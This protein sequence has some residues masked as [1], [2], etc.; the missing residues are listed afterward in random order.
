M[1]LVQYREHTPAVSGNNEWIELVAP[2]ASLANQ[3]ATTEFV[4][5]E[6]RNKPDAITACILYGAELGLG[7]MVSLSK[8]AVIQG[9]PA[10]YAELGRALALAAGH[11]IWV[12]ES[13][14]TR[15]TVSG[16]RKGS[17]HVQTVTW[18]SDDV[19]K[20]GISNHN[21]AKYP[22]QM[23]LARASAELVRAM[24]PDALGGIAVFAEE[25]EVM[26][27]DGPVV[28]SEPLKATTKR[29]RL[30]PVEERPEQPAADDAGEIEHAA[31]GPSKA[32][33]AKAMALFTEISVIDRAERLSLT[34]AYIGREVESWKDVTKA[35]A[36]T[37]IDRLETEASALRPVGNRD[38]P[39]L[40]GED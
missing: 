37:V 22:R 9:K 18:T 25:A 8:I 40:P 24:C 26:A 5:K 29:R 34:S 10:P 4:P 39:P 7:P 3:I 30:Q 28:A 32:Q 1:S 17:T 16:K 27:D 31:D 35:E 38:L 11:E 2:A 23:L 13:T 6:F 15:V 20:A 12:E 19:K 36:G 21:Y 14:N 33:T